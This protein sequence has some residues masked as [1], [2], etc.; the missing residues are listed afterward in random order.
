VNLCGNDNGS[1]FVS[2]QLERA[3][4]ILGIRLVHSRPG[5]PAGRGKIERV[6]GT[7]RRQF[8][9][10]L[11]ARGGARDLAEFNRLFAAWVEGVYHRRVHSETEQPPLERFL[12]GEVPPRLPSPAELREAFLWAERRLVSKTAM[13]GLHGN[14]YQVDPAL[15]GATVELVFDPFDLTTIEVRYQNRPMGTARLVK[16][17]R[18]VHPQATPEATP[19]S[20]PARPTGIDYLAMV[21]A[22]L[23]AQTRR[24]IATPSCPAR[25]RRRRPRVRPGPR[26]RQAQRRRPSHSQPR[27]HPATH[28]RRQPLTKEPT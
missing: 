26:R 17:G 15:V 22:K 16:V 9:V 1:P 19:A 13:V 11:Q 10:E 5:E 18:H 23:A 27:R 3:C 14:R 7:V 12:A 4:A 2:K 28:P 25:P 6:F 24:T 20:A 8:L 21:E